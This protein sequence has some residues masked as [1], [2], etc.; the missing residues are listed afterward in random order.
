M[1]VPGVAGVCAGVTATSVR[2]VVTLVLSL[3]LFTSPIIAAR[4][5]QRKIIDIK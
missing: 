5:G 2:A 1:F 4:D 3:S